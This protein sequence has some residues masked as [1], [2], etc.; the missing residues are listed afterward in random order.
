MYIKSTSISDMKDAY[1]VSGKNVV[2]TGGNRGI[3][4][5]IVQAFAE[6]GANVVIL[7]RN[8]ASGQTA[9]AEIE[10]FGSKYA[11]FQCD[12]SDIES[13]KT[14]VA[15]VFKVFDNVDVLVNNAGIDTTIPFLSEEGL[16]EW[17]RI[18]NTNLHGPANVVHEIAPRMVD[19]GKGG[20][21]INITSTSGQRVS[22][23]KA[24][25]NAPYSTSKAGLDIFSRYLAV[26]LGDYGIRVNSIAPGP[27]HSDLDNDLPP[28]FVEI[29]ENVLPAH[30]VGEPI[31]IGGLC[32][33]MASPAGAMVT[34]VN[35]AF[36]GGLL[37][38]N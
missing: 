23:A 21:I 10:K 17:H 26:V 38:V 6:S 24:H 28:S 37:C 5:G 19:A 30:R 3:G 22:G 15:E 20:T 35:W 36:D 16:K 13:V 27:I 4:R 8:I 9:V 12:V 32:V 34:G 14:A 31:E 11:A 1:Y 2:V 25:D 33:Y 7:C 29:I 18:I